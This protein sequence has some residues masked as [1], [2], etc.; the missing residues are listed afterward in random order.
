MDTQRSLDW[1]DKN[2]DTLPL[3]QGNHYLFVIGIDAYADAHIQRLEN[4]ERDAQALAQVLS[5]EYG[6]TVFRALYSEAATK[7]AIIQAFKDLAKQIS[8][9]DSLIIYYAGHGWYDP[10]FAAGYLVPVDAVHKDEGT[11]LSNEDFRKYIRGINSRHTLLMLDSCFSGAMLGRDLDDTDRSE[12]AYENLE[13]LPSR[14]CIAAGRIEK[15]SD[16]Y[17][18]NGGP[19]AQAAIT[20]LHNTPKRVFL[21]SE[22]GNHLRLAVPNNARQQPINAP[23]QDTGHQNGELVFRRTHTEAKDWDI[24]QQKNSVLAYTVFLQNYPDSQFAAQARVLRA[25]LEEESVWKDAQRADTISAYEDYARRF[26]VGGQYVAAAQQRI[27]ALLEKAR[28]AEAQTA[29]VAPTQK[30]AAQTSSKSRT[31]RQA[32]EQSAKPPL[33]TVDISQSQSSPERKKTLLWAG[34][35]AVVVGVAAIIW[36]A[37]RPEPKPQR[38]I[39]PQRTEGAKTLDP[40]KLKQQGIGVAPSAGSGTSSVPAPAQQSAKEPPAV[41]P[42]Q[43][44][45]SSRN[46]STPS[47]VTITPIARELIYEASAWKVAQEKNTLAAYEEYLKKYPNGT[48][49]EEAKRAMAAIRLRTS[50]KPMPR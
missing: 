4:A 32:K 43:Q 24:A 48:H 45:A 39:E 49:A 31:P 42:T 22:L 33:P 11:Y 40:Q 15:V 29:S 7:R 6:Y 44:N 10:A 9:H 16:G 19:F 1:E 2:A 28:T 30:S 27:E 37:T 17:S 34:V 36:F 47:T 38:I 18:G 8:P 35:G 13:A 20:F 12:A 14:M 50:V 41:Q 46:P 21:A 3:P 23:L 25:G 5:E 26:A